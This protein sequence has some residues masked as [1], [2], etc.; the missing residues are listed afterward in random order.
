MDKRLKRPGFFRAKRMFDLSMSFL[1]LNIKSEKETVRRSLLGGI[2]PGWLDFNMNAINGTNFNIKTLKRFYCHRILQLNP[3]ESLPISVY[4]RFFDLEAK[5]KEHIDLEKTLEYSENLEKLMR[6]LREV[7]YETYLNFVKTA[8]EVPSI[9]EGNANAKAAAYIEFAHAM[10]LYDLFV[11]AGMNIIKVS[12]DSMQEE[13]N[14]YS[15]QGDWP[16]GMKVENETL[17]AYIPLRSI[18]TVQRVEGMVR[19][20]TRHVI[21]LYALRSMVQLTEYLCTTK[22]IKGSR[23]EAIA[24]PVA[25]E[26]YDNAMKNM[27]EEDLS[28]FFNCL[29]VST[30]GNGVEKHRPFLLHYQDKALMGRLFSGY[31]VRKNFSSECLAYLN[32]MEQWLKKDEAWRMEEDAVIHDENHPEVC[33]AEI[34]YSDE[35]GDFL[36]AGKVP[37]DFF[38]DA[39]REVDMGNVA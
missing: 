19:T 39:I 3:E 33:M 10:V 18:P 4:E 1:D 24:A 15:E 14:A 37:W 36:P 31:D 21:A 12:L 20:E 35:E 25:I 7:A 27:E 28:A 26:R 9:E 23:L 6:R 13:I 11:Q 16:V 29:R 30:R 32:W 17:F 8:D 34:V 38:Y 22:K 2:Y 5:T